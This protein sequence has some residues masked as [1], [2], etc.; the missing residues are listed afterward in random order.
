MEHLIYGH[1]KMDV[2]KCYSKFSC[3]DFKNFYILRFALCISFTH[4]YAYYK[5]HLA[6][7]GMCRREADYVRRDDALYDRMH[8]EICALLL[9]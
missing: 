2:S 6:S 1:F 7:V 4:A 3:F 8:Y 9:K 5:A